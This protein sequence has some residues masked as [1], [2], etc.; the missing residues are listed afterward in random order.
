M[1]HI[2][3]SALNPVGNDK[4]IIAHIVNDKGAW[5]AGFV[6]P[7]G[8]KFPKAKELY[9]KLKQH[10][11]GLIQVVDA[12]IEDRRGWI[13]NMCAQT[14]GAPYPLDMDALKSC[15]NVTEAFAQTVNAKVHI[16][17]IGCGLAGGKWENISKLIPDSWNVYTLLIEIGRFPDEDY[18]HAF[19]S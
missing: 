3:G 18:E 8:L 6:I 12:S 13:I 11:R 10:R 15:I 1:K 5:G 14:L 17:R 9:L 2:L 7:L 4:F 19:G 16:P